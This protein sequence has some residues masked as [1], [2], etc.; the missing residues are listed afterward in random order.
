MIAA[1]KRACFLERQNVSW[2]FDHAKQLT[3]A[4]RIGTDVAKFVGSEV[5]AELAGMNSFS[6]F[7]NRAR[8]LLGLIAA[9][10]H[11]PERDPFGRA[12]TDCRHL[13]QLSHLITQRGWILRF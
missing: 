3:R 7:R 4:R 11:H 2:L 12:R 1:A 10:L 5:A 13:S 6:R 9:R 8:A